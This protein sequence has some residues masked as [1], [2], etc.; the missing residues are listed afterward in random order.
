MAQHSPPSRLTARVVCLPGDGVGPEIIDVARPLLVSAANRAGITL[1]LL[2][3]PIGG[4][5]Y[6]ADGDPL[7]ASTEA[8]CRAADA[9]LLGAVG[10]PRYDALPPALRPEQGLLRL[11]RALGVFANLRPVKVYPSLVDR[12]PLKASLLEG[13]DLVVVRELLSGLYFGEPR[14][15]EGD[16][17]FNTMAYEKSE[18]LRVAEVAFELARTRREAGRPGQVTSVDKAN[19]LE[20]S[21]LWREVVSELQR[22]RYPDVPLTHQYV[23]SAAMDLIRRPASFDVVLTENLFGDILTDEAAVLA[24]SIGLL[25]SASLGAGP[26]LYEPIHGS[27]PDIA[28]RGVANPIGAVLSAASLLRLS[29]HLPAEAARLEA[30]VEAVLE[31]GHFTADL[32]GDV[33]TAQMGELICRALND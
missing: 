29:L 22:T 32:G 9:V 25:P 2:E 27:A 23:D 19:V 3:L 30:A 1:E 17:A 31:A 16:R 4:A 10:A 24:G 28:G 26:G 15:I 20:V 13:T 21:R 5:G 6:D 14:G 7:P 33:S 12:A 18:I 8:A 11:R